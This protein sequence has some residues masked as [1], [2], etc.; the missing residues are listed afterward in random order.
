MRGWGRRNTQDAHT[1]VPPAALAKQHA[2]LARAA[3]S[4]SSRRSEDHRRP[5]AGLE[6]VLVLRLQGLAEAHHLCCRGGVEM[7]APLGIGCTACTAEGSRR[8]DVVRQL[9]PASDG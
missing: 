5:P 1:R 4:P 2:A 6:D 9:T 8:G 3:P 7:R